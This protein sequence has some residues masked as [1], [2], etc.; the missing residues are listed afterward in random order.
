M[1]SRGFTLID[2]VTTLAIVSVLLGVGLPNLTSHI[3]HSRV[4]NATQDLFESLE[5]TRTKAVFSNTRATIRKLNNW[6][7]GWEVFI[8]E[9][10]D[11]LLNNNEVVVQKHEKLN[12]VRIKAN[13]HVSDYV[14]YVESGESRKANKTSSAGAFQAGTFTVCPQGKGKGYELILARGGRVRTHEISEKNC[15]A[16]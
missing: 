15:A 4:H 6:E 14:S 3:Q 1:R 12:A 13:T 9:N 11:G 10:N 2:L 5:L 8:D 16:I 7:N